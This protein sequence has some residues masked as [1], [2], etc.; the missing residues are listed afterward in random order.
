MLNQLAFNAEEYTKDTSHFLFLLTTIANSI[1]VAWKRR[2]KLPLK[3]VALETDIYE[4]AETDLRH[5]EGEKHYFPSPRSAVLFL[6]DRAN[7][8][9]KRSS[10]DEF[11]QIM[12]LN[13][14]KSFKPDSRV[15]FELLNECKRR[16]N[17]ISCGGIPQ[18]LQTLFT[19]FS[20]NAPELV[21]ALVLYLDRVLAEITLHND[22]GVLQIEG[23]RLFEISFLQ[24]VNILG[25]VL[26]IFDRCNLNRGDLATQ[27]A[28]MMERSNFQQLDGA[29]VQALID[30]L[31]Y[32]AFSVDRHEAIDVMAILLQQKLEGGAQVSSG[33][34]AA[35]AE[36]F[37]AAPMTLNPLRHQGLIQAIKQKANS[38]SGDAKALQAILKRIDWRRDAAGTPPGDE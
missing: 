37:V 26:S 28:E 32:I 3:A 10:S 18:V 21:E 33:Q 2:T 30:L 17:E 9:I 15:K 22:P 29:S 6:I 23:S 16:V 34:L 14:V 8:L 27:V 11:V 1:R 13:C 38:S 25:N 5:Q 4:K 7:A 31:H 20:P 35:I 24:D 12:L 36:C 19:L